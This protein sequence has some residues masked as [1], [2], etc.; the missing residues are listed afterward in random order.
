MSCISI[1]VLSTYRLLRLLK[2]DL[3]NN[4]IGFQ[5]RE[6]TSRKGFV[7]W[8]R[9]YI[10]AMR[11]LVTTMF[12][13]AEHLAIAIT[14]KLGPNPVLEPTYTPR[15]GVKEYVLMVIGVLCLALPLAMR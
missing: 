10:D 5:L 4:V 9:F 8:I 14:L 13:R 3:K 11:R 15:S 7:S 1:A 12:S 6:Y 2:V